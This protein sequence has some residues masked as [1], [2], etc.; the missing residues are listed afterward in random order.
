M[1]DTRKSI[2]FIDKKI[3]SK[4]T[5][6]SFYCELSNG[7]ER[8]EQINISKGAKFTVDNSF[9]YSWER[10]ISV[11]IWRQYWLMKD[12]DDV[13]LFSCKNNANDIA[14]DYKMIKSAVGK[15][16]MLTRN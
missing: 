14:I 1:P 16:L 7:R 5:R 12:N 10:A 15:Y 13:Q 9:G 8:K 6:D 4:P 3:I 11:R 2:Y